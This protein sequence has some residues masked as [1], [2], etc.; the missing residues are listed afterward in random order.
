M[1]SAR[2]SRCSTSWTIT[3]LNDI[4]GLENP[5][6]ERLAQWIFEQLRPRLPLLSLVVVHETCTAGARYQRPERCLKPPW[7]RAR[8]RMIR[9][10]GGVCTWSVLAER[11]CFALER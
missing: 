9:Q 5:T 2:S 11:S 1:S 6:S 4:P 7:A 8:S 3:Y 10:A